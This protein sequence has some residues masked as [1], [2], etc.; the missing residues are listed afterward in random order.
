MVITCLR[1]IFQEKKKTAPIWKAAFL[2]PDLLF[3]GRIAV[4]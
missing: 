3:G 4:G 1:A 2:T